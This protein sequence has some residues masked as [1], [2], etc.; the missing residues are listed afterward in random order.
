MLYNIQE[1]SGNHPSCYYALYGMT[2]PQLSDVWHSHVNTDKTVK[3]ELGITGFTTLTKS[4]QSKC[5]IYQ[6]NLINCFFILCCKII[7]H[8]NQ[9]I[10]INIFKLNC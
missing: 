2:A 1:S 5:S 3:R 4:I 8:L 10:K 6:M 9:F 7:Y